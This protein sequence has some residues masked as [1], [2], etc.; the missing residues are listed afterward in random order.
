MN[1]DGNCVMCPQKGMWCDTV[2]GFCQGQDGDCDVMRIKRMEAAFAKAKEMAEEMRRTSPR[3]GAVL[4]LA[5]QLD[6]AIKEFVKGEAN[7]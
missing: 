6:K 5:D 3:L 1:L 4:K 7:A 2:R